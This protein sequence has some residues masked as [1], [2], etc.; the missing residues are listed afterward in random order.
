MGDWRFYLCPAQIIQPGD[1]PA[2]WGL[3]WTAGRTIRKVYGFPK[4]NTRWCSE[5]P[6]CGNKANETV[7]LVSALRRLV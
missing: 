5:R 3:L 7:M 4:G 2:G 6:F 1:L